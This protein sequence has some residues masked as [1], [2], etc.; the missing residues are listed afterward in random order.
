[1]RRAVAES[2]VAAVKVEVSVE[3]VGDLQ[4]GLFEAGKRAAVG[5]QFGF[6]RAPAGLGLGIIVGI[7]QP[8]I[9]GQGLGFSM[10]ARHAELVYW[11]PRSAWIIRP[12][13]GWRSVSACSRA[14][15]TSSVGICWSRC[16][17]TTRCKQVSRQVA[18]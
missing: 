9:A 5:E 12:G 18:S 10:R 3:V 4:T 11:L 16:Q 7:A 17:P 2:R 13:A 14:V 1:M 8:A 15:S 6:E